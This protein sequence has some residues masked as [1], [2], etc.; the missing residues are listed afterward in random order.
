[1]VMERWG[2]SILGFHFFSQGIP[3]ITLGVLSRSIISSMGC[4]QSLRVKVVLTYQH[5][6]PFWF[7]VSSTL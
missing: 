1:M 4:E 5:M 2:Q 6:V 7:V 3:R